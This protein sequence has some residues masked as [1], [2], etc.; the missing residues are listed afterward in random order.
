MKLRR[1][2]VLMAVAAAGSLAIGLLVASAGTSQT[3]A[4]SPAFS[5]AQLVEPSGDN[6]LGWN[7][8]VYNQ[9]YSTLNQ[10]DATNVRQLKVA[11][12]RRMVIPGLKVKPG[13]LGVFAEQQPVV[14]EGIMYMPDSSGNMWSIDAGTGERIWTRRAKFPK[15]L[16]PLLPSRGVGQGDGK[17]YLALGDATISALDQSTGRVVWKKQIADYKEGYY[18]TNAP[19]YYAGMVITGTS[20]GDSGSRG[21]VV[22]LNAKTGKELWRFYVIPEKK[23]EPGYWTWPKKKAFLGGG[24]MWNTPAIV[25]SSA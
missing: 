16:T 22:A 9:R 18:F 24:A 23:G 6:W 20:G 14:Y 21:F 17:V 4:P 15:G 11:W 1:M 3:P 13:P 12:S 25:L 8:N 7:G 5:A 19:T 10:I 2:P